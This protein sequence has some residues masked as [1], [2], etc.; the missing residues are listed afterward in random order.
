[1]HH[2]ARRA[3][4]AAPPLSADPS[5]AAH[6]ACSAA[7]ALAAGPAQ[8]GPRMTAESSG[9][10]CALA[11]RC[12]RVVACALWLCGRCECGAWRAPATRAA[13][14]PGERRRA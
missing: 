11:L 2:G 1:M 14:S 4:D 12:A 6:A 5:C 8:T 10:L 3:A 7:P 9:A 13:G